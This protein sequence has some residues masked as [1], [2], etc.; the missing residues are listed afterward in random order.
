MAQVTWS[1][2]DV[3]VDTPS[4]VY[5][6]PKPVST[7]GTPYKG[8]PKVRR[9]KRQKDYVVEEVLPAIQFLVDLNIASPDLLQQVNAAIDAP[10]TRSSNH[11]QLRIFYKTGKT[12]INDAREFG[13]VC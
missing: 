10:V 8:C 13:Y 12:M 4:E 5:E 1:D 11:E 3:I 2:Y 6:I 9:I 7:M